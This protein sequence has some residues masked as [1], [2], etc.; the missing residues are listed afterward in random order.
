MHVVRLACERPEALGRSL[1]PGDG[2]ALAR[3]LIAEGLVA[4]IAAATVRR[5][6]RSPT[7]KPW[8][9]HLWLHPKKPREAAFYATVS[10]LIDLYTRPRRAEERVLSRDE[11]TAL[12][13]RPRP[14]PTLP[15]QP[16]HLPTRHAHEDKRAGA[17]NLVAAFAPR[18]GQVD[19]P[20]DDRKRPRE[21]IAFLEPLD[22]EIEAHI[23]MS[24]VVCDHGST[25]HGQEARQW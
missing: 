24:H 11:K 1:S 19:G 3:Q 9:Q 10:A 4:D 23:T 17:L 25:H 20:C 22:Q 7:L 21:C 15:A 6:L 5:I 2:H 8:R 12:Q 14:F 13:P 16:Q 18:S